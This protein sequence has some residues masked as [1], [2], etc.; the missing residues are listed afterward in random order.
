MRH[1][2]IAIGWWGSMATLVVACERPA[3]PA[4]SVPRE[5][6][7]TPSRGPAVV[8]PGIDVLLD[9]SMSLLRGRRVGFVTNV[10]AVDQR[11]RSAIA[12]LREANVELVAL[13]GPEHG[14]TATAAPG[15]KVAS[16]VDSATRIPIYSLYGQTRAPTEEMLRG[17]DLLLVDLPD[18]GARYYTWIATTI[19]VM[20]AAAPRRIPVVV[21]DRPNPI[22]GVMQGNIL[23]T[24][25]TSAVGRLAVPMRHGL[26]LGE[27]ARLARHDLDIAVDL[28]VIPAAGWHRTMAFDQTGLP[29]LPP[30][31]NLRDLDALYHYTG[32]CLFEGT[33]LSVGRGTDAAFHQ[34]G[35]PWLD[36]AAVV[37]AMRAANLP[38]VEFRGVVFTPRR[39]GDGKFADT[40]VVGVRLVITD[41]EQYDPVRTAVHLLAAIGAMHPDR[42]RI[43][44]SFDRLAGGPALRTALLRRDP[45]ERILASWQPALAAFRVRVQPFLL[46]H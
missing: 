36:T 9:D 11:G 34:V 24:A 27:H 20:K 42:I 43:G 35:A 44:G 12:R 13:F 4:G 5:A 8:R 25:F 28:R 6:P 33:A 21:L 32:T 39:P 10:N 18:V 23:D 14:L 26:T 7:A 1:G 19:E 40:T 22:T 31:P 38:G 41:H 3:R 16:T 2:L 15:E 46:Y 17:I 30:S 45:P 37:A 29:F